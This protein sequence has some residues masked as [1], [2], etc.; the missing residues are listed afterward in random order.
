MQSQKK[1][2]FLNLDLKQKMAGIELSSLNR[3][4]L[5]STYFD[6]EPIFLTIGFN[7]TLF[8]DK[9]HVI[10]SNRA[11]KNLSIMSIYDY[12]LDTHDIKTEKSSDRNISRFK[13]LP[14]EEEPSDV[15]MYD[16]KG[17]LIGFCRRHKDDLGLSYINYFNKIGKIFRRETYD[18]RGFIIRTELIDSKNNEEDIMQDLFHRANGSIGIIKSSTIK[19][20]LA[21]LHFIQL[22]DKNNAFVANF[23]N[24]NDF[25]EYW[26]VD[27]IKNN[28]D[29][30]FFVDRCNE[31]QNIMLNAKNKIKNQIKIFSVLHGVHTGGDVFGGP[32]NGWYKTTME[33]RDKL[34]GI[35]VLTE[36]QKKDIE[37]RYGSGNYHVIPH[38]YEINLNSAPL[39]KRAKNKIVYVARYSAEKKHEW[40]IEIFKKVLEKR[41]NTE[42]H[43]YGYGNPDVENKVK[44]LIDEF[45]LKEKCILHDFDQNVDAI[46]QN[47]S[48]SILTSDTEGFCMGI[49]ESLANGCPVISFNIKY[50]P[51]ELIKNGI[52]GFLIPPF[53]LD[54][55]SEKIIEILNNDA[56]HASLI[57]N[58]P[59]TVEHFNHK[60]IAN[61]WSSII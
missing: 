17:H 56:L 43:F 30:I 59:K 47:A 45:N 18:S 15:R 3:T 14:V 49:L 26:L 60:N 31:F 57:L 42:L 13:L 37:L 52:N 58:A 51:S 10:K 7:N 16:P 2:F 38:S 20:N 9:E 36:T 25:I 35:V 55:F 53:K 41:P 48:L 4:K 28:P 40:A 44:S 6:I 19:N 54:E 8:K 22:I 21:S 27:I 46:Y 29:A 24:E 39:S 50:G 12:F 61:K 34:D 5:F 11:S 1:V 33:N 23:E 32:T